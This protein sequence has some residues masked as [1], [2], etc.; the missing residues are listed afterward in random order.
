MR[1]ASRRRRSRRPARKAIASGQP[2]WRRRP[3]GPTR[4]SAAR[5]ARSH[6]GRPI[7]LDRAAGAGV[8]GSVDPLTGTCTGAMCRWHAVTRRPARTVTLPRPLQARRA[9]A[10]QRTRSA[11]REVLGDAEATAPPCRPCAAHLVRRH[12]PGACRAHRQHGARA[13][14]HRH[15]ENP[16]Q[17]LAD[18]GGGAATS[19]A[20]IDQPLEPQRWWCR[21]PRREAG[22]WLHLDEHARARARGGETRSGLP[23]P[24]RRGVGAAPRRAVLQGR[25]RGADVRRSKQRWCA[26]RRASA[27]KRPTGRG[28]AQRLEQLD[29]AVAGGQAARPARP[30]SAI[31]ASRTSGARP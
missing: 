22:G 17:R 20:L 16:E 27:G 24:A 12:L 23:A 11:R 15:L 14:V 9:G 10:A 3:A 30:R 6:V 1:A 7:L 13:A 21:R 19:S 5:A 18:V 25:Q 31:S 26:P 4:R 28:R 2:R 29:L 8:C